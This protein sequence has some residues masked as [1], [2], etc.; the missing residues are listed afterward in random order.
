MIIVSIM[1]IE[2]LKFLKHVPPIDLVKFPTNYYTWLVC[3]VAALN[4]TQGIFL[5]TYSSI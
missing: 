5:I 2:H 3:E 4:M 1:L